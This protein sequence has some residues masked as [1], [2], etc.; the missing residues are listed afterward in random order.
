MPKY[1]VAMEEMVYYSVYVEAAN[2]DEAIEKARAKFANGLY[3][4]D[5]P[6]DD[7]PEVTEVE[8]LP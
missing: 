8:E 3:D 2:A 4:T 6:G 5:P 7:D 1:R